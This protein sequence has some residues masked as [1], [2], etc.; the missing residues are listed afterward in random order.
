MKPNDNVLFS[1]SGLVS[2]QE[3]HVQI[4]KF[5]SNTTVHNLSVDIQFSFPKNNAATNVF[6]SKW[7]QFGRVVKT[8]D[9]KSS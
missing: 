7:R 4:S 6:C 8:P 9:L 2:S 3:R 5:F 1:V